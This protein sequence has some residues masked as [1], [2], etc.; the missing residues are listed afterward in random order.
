M[1]AR[2]FGTWLWYPK[3][4]VVVG[5][6][7]RA[8][9]TSVLESAIEDGIAPIVFDMLGEMGHLLNFSERLP[10]IPVGRVDLNPLKPFGDRTFFFN[11][12]AEILA[13]AGQ[14][15][16]KRYLKAYKFLELLRTYQSDEP[17]ASALL[18]D[19]EVSELPVE[20]DLIELLTPLQEYSLCFK[21]RILMEEVMERGACIDLSDV[22]SSYIRAAVSLVFMLRVLV[23]SKGHSLLAVTHP[24][25]IWGA[26][27][28]RLGANSVADVFLPEALA[29]RGVGLLL[30][31]ES[32][33]RVPAFLW[34]KAWSVFLAG[35]V[36]RRDLPAWA[37]EQ[38]NYQ[39]QRDSAM[40]LTRDGH[41][42][43]IRVEEVHSYTQPSESEVLERLRDVT[44]GQISAAFPRPLIEQFGDRAKLAV[45]IM[46][47]IRERTPFFEGLS[48]WIK[49]K[50]GQASLDVLGG[51]V[52]LQFVKIV[53][54]ADG[55]RIELTKK[56]QST[57]SE[58]IRAGE[59]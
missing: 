5:P 20:S 46:S 3:A 6:N 18:S 29:A 35:H 42:K 7:H 22:S 2:R 57:L 31:C 48:G 27:Q 30:S 14:L 21:E 58:S 1:N 50:L 8:V 43:H 38:L 52:R 54:T 17:T 39:F 24:L 59:S 10:L 13:Y 47:Y 53:Q 34:R 26:E 9:L 15:R 40:F 11:A 55:A 19:L 44:S 4:S 49:N 33:K 28:D 41:V 56:G 16:Y 45:E 25:L 51:L 37:S 12:L 36:E 23:L 32:P